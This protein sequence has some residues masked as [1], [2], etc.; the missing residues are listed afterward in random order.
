MSETDPLAIINEAIEQI[1]EA[2]NRF[3]ADSALLKPAAISSLSRLVNDTA[4]RLQETLGSDSSL[5]RQM[6]SRLLPEWLD[7]WR[8]S[9]TNMNTLCVQQLT[10][11]LPAKSSVKAANWWKRRLLAELLQTTDPA[12]VRELLEA[13]K[14]VEKP[15]KT[16]DGPLVK[17]PEVNATLKTWGQMNFEEFLD[18][19]PSCA[20]SIVREA[21]RLRGLKG[22]FTTKAEKRRLHE[23][24]KR[25]YQNTTLG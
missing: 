15:A 7:A 22:K 11:G 16:P 13:A 4:A 18:A 21:A 2:L 25:F 19:F 17:A 23:E 9:R 12:A 14:P 6:F 5:D 10:R 3:E 8:Q 24:A 1:H 20:K